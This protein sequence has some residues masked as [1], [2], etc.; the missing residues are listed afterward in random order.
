MIFL[1]QYLIYFLSPKNTH[2]PGNRVLFLVGFSGGRGGGR[3][4]SGG[5]GGGRG[6]GGGGR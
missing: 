4:M 5:R 2:P 6:R 1:W 3:G